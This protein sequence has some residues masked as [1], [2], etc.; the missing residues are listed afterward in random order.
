MLFLLVLVIFVSSVFFAMLGLGGG[1]FY[2]PAMIFFGY[3]I[4]SV[5]QP[6]ALVLTGLTSATAAFTYAR[7]SMTEWPIALKVALPAVSAALLGGYAARYV[8]D[9]AMIQIFA[10]AVLFVA[11]RTA[12]SLKIKKPDPSS[13]LVFDKKEFVYLLFAVVGISFFSAMVGL[14]GG[15]LLVPVLLL[16][17]YPGKKAAALSSFLVV[18]NSLSGLAGRLGDLHASWIFVASLSLAVIAGA[19]AGALLML[20]K[21]IKSEYINYGYTVFLILL[22][23]KMMYGVYG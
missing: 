13:S 7:R 22:F 9:K 16:L 20:G 1:M 10:A 21:K 17:S 3:A 18:L 19:R 6:T 11:I 14:G 12:M 2:V 23:A 15:S 5:A 8:P 4:K